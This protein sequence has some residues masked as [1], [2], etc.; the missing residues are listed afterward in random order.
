MEEEKNTTKRKLLTEWNEPSFSVNPKVVSMSVWNEGEKYRDH[1]TMPKV[2]REYVSEIFSLNNLAKPPGSSIE[3]PFNLKIPAVE[4]EKEG[5]QLMVGKDDESQTYF[6]FFL[7]RVNPSD[8][9]I[10]SYMFK[11]SASSEDSPHSTPRKTLEGKMRKTRFST[12]FGRV[13]TDQKT[14]EELERREKEVE[15]EEE[16]R[17]RMKEKKEKEQKERALKKK[18]A[19]EEKANQ[20]K[21]REEQRLKKHQEMEKKRKEKEINRTT[22]KQK[23]ESEKE[24]RKNGELLHSQESQLNEKEK[25][26][27]TALLELC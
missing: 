7:K 14:I 6:H 4:E 16:R 1:K 22:K 8:S 11:S 23:T 26:A 13:W 17:L 27:L 21:A 3:L 12:E 20:K 15:M 10:G 24:N 25:V 9:A 5:E 19:E 18:T 2:T